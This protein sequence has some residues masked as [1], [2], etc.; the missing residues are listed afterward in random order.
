MTKFKK[1]PTCGGNGRLYRQN[2]GRTCPRCAGTGRV[3]DHSI[4]QKS[5]FDSDYSPK[6]SRKGRSSANSGCL[7]LIILAAAATV[8]KLG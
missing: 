6:R 5:F 4:E 3:A 8:L 1:C 2:T 7:V